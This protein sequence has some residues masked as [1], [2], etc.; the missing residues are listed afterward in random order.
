MRN[1]NAKKHPP[2]VTEPSLLNEWFDLAFQKALFWACRRRSP[3]LGA[4]CLHMGVWGAMEVC[5]LQP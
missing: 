5:G 2:K 4:V 1:W 3:G